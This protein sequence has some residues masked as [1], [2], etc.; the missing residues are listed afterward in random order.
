MTESPGRIVGLLADRRRRDELVGLVALVGGAAAA[1]PRVGVVLGLAVARA[2]RRPSRCGPS[3]CRGPS[4]SSGRRRSR[5]ARRPPRPAL[6]DR[7]EQS[8]RRRRRRVAPVGEGVDDEVLDARLARRC[9]ISALR[10]RSEECTPPSETS[11]IRCTRGASR[12]ASRSTSFSASEPSSTASSMRARSCGTIAPGAEV[13]VADLGVAHLPGGQA[14]GLAAGGQLRV[15]VALPQPVEHRRVGERD[16]VAR[17]VRRQP[18]AVEDDEA[19]GGNRAH[20]VLS[21]ARR[22]DDRGER[23]RR[24]GWRRRRARRRRRAAPAARR[25]SRA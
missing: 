2:G 18:P 12:S 25:R 19:D 8:A 11:P 3:A 21:L 6:L 20:G 23:A 24:R 4:R 9:S 13:E 7:R 5:C 17:P 16:R 22:L 10:W 1:S 14:D 15:V